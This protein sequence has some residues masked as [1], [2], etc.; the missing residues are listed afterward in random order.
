MRIAC[1]HTADSNIAVFDEAAIGLKFDSLQ[2]SHIVRSDLLSAAE[3][4]G[5]LTP[6]ITEQTQTALRSLC[7]DHDAVLLTCSTLGPSVYGMSAATRTPVI[8]VDEALAEQAISQGGRIVVLCAVETT[9]K[10]TSEL[11]LNA[12]A[13]KESSIEIQ[14]I[15]NIWGLFKAGDVNGYFLAI[16]AAADSAYAQGAN[17]VALAQ[18]SMAGA[19]LLVKNGVTPLTSP[20]CGLLAAV[21]PQQ[22]KVA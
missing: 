17:V 3:N 11:F 21:Q 8:R 5:G 13:G 12:N 9:I 19:A 10:P 2:I 4:A 20:M 18:A 1:L 16:A 22:N 14:L 6:E 7:N 15:P